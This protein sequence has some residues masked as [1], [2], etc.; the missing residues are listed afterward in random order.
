MLV[1]GAQV[2]KYRQLQYTVSYSAIRSPAASD[3]LF[4]SEKKNLYGFQI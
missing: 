4:I 1:K 2:W 3:I